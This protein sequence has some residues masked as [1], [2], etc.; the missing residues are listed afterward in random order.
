MASSHPN[1]P[2]RSPWLWRVAALATAFALPAQA[3]DSVEDGGFEQG[4]GLSSGGYCYLNGVSCTLSHWSGSGVRIAAD[5]GAWG[6]PNQLSGA[7]GQLG[8]AVLGLQNDSDL[9]QSLTFSSAGSY[10]LTWW[11]AGRPSYWNT[12]Y[13]VMLGGQTL[14]TYGVVAGQGW[15]QHSLMLQVQQAGPLLLTFDGQFVNPD[16]TALLDR[17]SLSAA[18]VPEP[19]SALLALAGV[20]LVARMRPRPL[21]ARRRR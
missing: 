19:A 12:Q 16:G 11:D 1:A 7:N 8:S 20:A 18:P 13:A 6:I 5:S 14:A 2:R 4:L 21:T 15:S 17:V 10:A 9:S 3:A